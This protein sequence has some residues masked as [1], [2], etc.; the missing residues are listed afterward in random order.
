MIDDLMSALES[1]K[2]GMEI[3]DDLQYLTYN[4]SNYESRLSEAQDLRRNG[5][6]VALIP[7]K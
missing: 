3:V 5:K 1:Q 4:A 7:E 2:A 6:K